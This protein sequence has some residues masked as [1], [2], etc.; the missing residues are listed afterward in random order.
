MFELERGLKRIRQAVKPFPKA[1]LQQLKDEGFA[2]PF[3]QLVACIISVRTL[4]EVTVPT[5]RRLFEK[6][7]RPADVLRLGRSGVERLIH[8]CAFN[9]VKAKTIFDAA[10]RIEREF[11]GKLPCDEQ[12]LLSLKGV[13]AKCAN[14]VLG[15]ACGT[16][17][18]AV[19][20]HV[21]R[22]TNRWGYVRA[23]TPEKTLA[24]LEARVPARHWTE[25]NALLVPFGK[26]ICT[27][28][29]P[30]C[31]TCPVRDMCEQV[32]VKEHR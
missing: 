12:V 29:L 30:H 1:A 28:R 21:H 20:V 7:R 6:A 9:K 11:G 32:G 13:G 8:S 23:S 24:A 19:D 26:H 18:I 4:E 2:S 14:L 15:L 16:P 25:L 3:E 27:G 10:R 17:R 31:S 5:A 22:I